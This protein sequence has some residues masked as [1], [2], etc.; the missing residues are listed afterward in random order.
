MNFYQVQPVPKHN[1]DSVNDATVTTSKH[2]F[3]EKSMNVCCCLNMYPV[4][5]KCIMLL[6]DLEITLT[7]FNSMITDCVCEGNISCFRIIIHYE[8]IPKDCSCFKNQGLEK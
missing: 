7:T 4:N 6:L 3:G 5:G 2:H 1:T 8:N